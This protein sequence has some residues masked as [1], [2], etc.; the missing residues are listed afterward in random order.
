MDFSEEAAQ[1]DCGGRGHLGAIASGRGT[2][3]LARTRAGRNAMD[4]S[5]SMAAALCGG[6]AESLTNEIIVE[7]FRRGDEWSA[8]VVRAASRPLGWAFAALHHA[9]GVERFVIIGGF[10]LA[11]GEGYRT[12]LARAA[13][14]SGWSLGQDWDSMVELGTLGDRASLLGAGRYA[15]MRRG[16]A[17]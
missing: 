14:G 12:H 16:V 17:K 3:T 9:L 6:D 8:D 5:S 11:L 1:C 10:A 7:A 15:T 4:F 13:S 2:L